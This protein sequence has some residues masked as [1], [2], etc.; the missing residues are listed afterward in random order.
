MCLAQLNFDRE[1]MISMFEFSLR[2]TYELLGDQ[3]QKA[4][5]ANKVTMKV[6]C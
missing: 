3:L 2:R 5:R 6:C 4:K 1:D